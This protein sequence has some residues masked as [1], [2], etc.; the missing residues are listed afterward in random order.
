MAFA[1]L[2][3]SSP[4][5][6]LLQRS[7]QQ[8]RLGHAYLFTGHAP[9]ELEAVARTLAKTINC[10][11]P[12]PPHE[13]L[14]RSDSCDQ[15]PA[16]RRIDA[17][18][19]PDVFW[20][21]PESKSRAITIGQVRDIMHAVNLKPSEAAWKVMVIVDADRM[22]LQAANAFLKTL[23]EPP[24]RSILLLLSTEPQRLLE[25]ILSRCLRLH[26]AGAPLQPVASDHHAW[27]SEFA[28]S[29]AQPQPSLLGRYRLLGQLLERLAKI[30]E[31]VETL[32]TERSPLHA[33]ADIDAD[34]KSKWEDELKASIEAEYRRQRTDLLNALH[35]WWRDVWISTHRIPTTLLTLPSLQS[36]AAAVAQRLSPLKAL[37]N[38]HKWERIRRTLETNV[39]EALALEVGLLQLNL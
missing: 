31:S 22:N 24:A 29:A 18:Q 15:C 1:D 3:G 5:I 39:Q 34:L 37:D 23:E 4:S 7:L 11:A 14:P 10:T 6:Q 20:V 16:C 13:R 38:L 27:L 25:T 35:W 30:R 36:D 9:A 21:R 33:R 8:A 17:Q 28:A 19:H 12:T 26:F 2:P 32:V